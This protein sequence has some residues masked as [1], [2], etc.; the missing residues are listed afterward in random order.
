MP[1]SE[2]VA[3][4]ARLDDR[5]GC[6]LAEAAAT[7]WGCSHAV[8]IRSSASHVFV[9]RR[10]VNDKRVV[11]RMRPE[12]LPAAEEILRRSAAAALTAAGAPVAPTG[13]G[14]PWGG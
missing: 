11:L 8:F 4:R 7:R 14:S 10:G 1:I 2:L 9:A 13:C 12:T 3:I 5:L 6:P